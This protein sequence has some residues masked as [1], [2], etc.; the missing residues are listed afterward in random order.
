MRHYSRGYA[1]FR[2]Q[3]LVPGGLWGQPKEISKLG[4]PAVSGPA[5]GFVL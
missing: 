2:R 3:S 1:G 5:P 4:G